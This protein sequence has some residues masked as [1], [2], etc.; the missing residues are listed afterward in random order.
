VLRVP[1]NMERARQRWLDVRK[2]ETNMRR[3][4]KHEEDQTLTGNEADA[5]RVAAGGEA[6]NGKNPDNSAGWPASAR[7]EAEAAVVRNMGQRGDVVKGTES[8][9]WIS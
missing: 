3:G 1:P 5:F 9:H 7:V 8:K 4:R 6:G 2:Q